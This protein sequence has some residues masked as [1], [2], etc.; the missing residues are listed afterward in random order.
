MPECCLCDVRCVCGLVFVLVVIVVAIL[1]DKKSNVSVT[2]VNNTDGKSSPPPPPPPPNFWLELLKKV[3]LGGVVISVSLYGF[4]I[5]SSEENREY[6]IYDT[7][8]E[9][10]AFIIGSLTAPKLKKLDIVLLK[11]KKECGLQLRPQVVDMM[12]DGD[13]AVIEAYARWR[14]CKNL[15]RSV[16]WSIYPDEREYYIKTYSLTWP[17]PVVVRGNRKTV[18]SKLPF[19]KIFF[20]IL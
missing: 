20:R 17:K 6:L 18:C 1:I 16:G 8:Q 19:L 12:V 10:N 2:Q 15:S 13:Q 9:N 11:E 3:F 4:C 14:I 7:N 5:I